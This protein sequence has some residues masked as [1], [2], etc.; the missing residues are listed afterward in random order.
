ME[1]NFIGDVEKHYFVF[2]DSLDIDFEKENSNIH[3]I[4]QKDLGWPDNTLMRFH[5][6]LEHEKELMG[7]DFLF[8][9]N[10]NL[11]VCHSITGD[12]FLPKG[13]DNLVATLH[14]GFYNKKRSKF[15]YENNKKSAAYI[16]RQEGKYYFAGGLNG[17]KTSAFL[18][19]IKTM[20][21]Q[22]DID[23]KNGVIAKW[24]DE[25][26]W[27]RY[28]IE[29]DDVK[30]LQ[31]SYLYPEGWS[32]PF[33]I[34]ILIRDKN[35]YGGHNVLRNKK[36]FNFKNKII[37]LAKKIPNIRKLIFYNYKKP[38]ILDQGFNLK[39]SSLLLVTIAFNNIDIIK[40][41]YKY[42]KMNLKDQFIYMIAD[43]SSLSNASKDI[44]IY[45]NSQ[46][47][48]YVKLPPN[49]YQNPSK[50][51]GMALKWVYK[52]I[53][54]IY[55]PLYF[56]FL[57][58]DILPYKE[59]SIIPLVRNGVF[60]LVQE[61]DTK[62][63]LWPGFCFFELKKLQ[64]VKINFMPS[65]GLDTGGANYYSL[66]KNID[67]DTLV[68]VPQVYIDTNTKKIVSNIDDQNTT[69]TIE[70]IGDWIH[71]MR[72]SNWNSQK[73][74]KTSSVEEIISQVKEIL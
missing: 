13:S 59:T 2:T 38:T 40:T 39:N 18:G 9:F 53:I 11:L 14:P 12:E 70:C 15:T 71:L 30:I 21:D 61:R 32:L 58:H 43:N 64:G 66:Y 1:K 57:D 51:H 8:F 55:N 28:L 31:P 24:H 34:N 68:K 44:E 5:I 48:P 29:R 3:R 41:Q 56:G 62:W 72:A 16:S 45:C 69:T 46:N 42:I 35:K 37:K 36:S 10:A 49:P 47:I 25:S 7:M 26:H 19:A 4:Y 22:V 60:G 74:N 63:Y 50:S 23:K 17:G 73:N 33:S 20:K 6:F 52:N 54:N 27:N 65:S 67:R